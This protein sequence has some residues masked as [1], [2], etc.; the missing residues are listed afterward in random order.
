MSIEKPTCS[1]KGETTENFKN[2]KSARVPQI[3]PLKKKGPDSF[4]H[5]AV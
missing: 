2:K 4:Y 1:E 5:F 3:A